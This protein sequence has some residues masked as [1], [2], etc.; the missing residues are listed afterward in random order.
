MPIESTKSKVETSDELIDRLEFNKSDIKKQHL[1][2]L[3]FTSP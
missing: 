3:P 2:L 1:L